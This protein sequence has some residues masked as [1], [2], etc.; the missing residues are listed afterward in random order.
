MSVVTSE[1]RNEREILITSRSSEDLDFS[2]APLDH[3]PFQCRRQ[4]IYW[5]TTHLVLVGARPPSRPTVGV[6]L[7][8]S[9]DPVLR[10][11]TEGGSCAHFGR[12]F[13][14]G[15]NGERD[16]QPGRWTVDV[17]NRAAPGWYFGW[18]IVREV[19][20]TLRFVPVST[21]RSSL[22]ETP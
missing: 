4:G 7:D 13:V 1:V 21:L 17:V 11:V 6:T 3:R 12:E 16:K 22:A 8:P 5:G 19:G 2:G 9:K 18:R 14:A 20:I 10:T 15:D